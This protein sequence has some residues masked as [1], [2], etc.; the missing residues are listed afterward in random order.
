MNSFAWF[1]LFHHI[2]V[3]PKIHHQF[4]YSP[5]FWYRNYS[6]SF[7]DFFLDYLKNFCPWLWKGNI[8]WSPFSSLPISVFSASSSSAMQ[9]CWV[10][11]TNIQPSSSRSRSRIWLPATQCPGDQIGQTHIY[12]YTS[13]SLRYSILKI[14]QPL[15]SFQASH[16]ATEFSEVTSEFLSACDCTKYSGITF[17]MP[18]MKVFIMKIRLIL[19][20]KMVQF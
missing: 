13:Q 7:F 10:T 16:I 17:R 4:Y 1:Q 12:C 6:F 3:Q 15:W 11:T 8:C 14:R 2:L 19:K 18:K 9:R 5:K 20:T